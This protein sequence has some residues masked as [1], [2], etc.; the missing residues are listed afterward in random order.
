MH[1]PDL[2]RFGL[3]GRALDPVARNE[4]ARPF[5]GEFDGLPA[6]GIGGLEDQA[7]GGF[8]I[9]LEDQLLDEREA[10]AG[11]DRAAQ[12]HVELERA[13]GRDERMRK[14][15]ADSGDAAGIAPFRQ[16]LHGIE[17]RR[18]DHEFL[19]P[20][21]AFAVPQRLDE[22]FAADLGLGFGRAA[23]GARRSRAERHRVTPRNDAETMARQR[24]QPGKHG[25]E[26]RR[27]R[28]ADHGD[29]RQPARNLGQNGDERDA[30]DRQRGRDRRSRRGEPAADR[31]RQGFGEW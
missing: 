12:R 26:K 11:A 29:K 14:G 30:A 24:L 9:G 2:A 15:S 7:G 16:H 23:A 27:Q 10:L 25:G 19:Q 17:R 31:K 1:G 8:E 18:L 28:H 4:G 22:E 5:E 20:D 3:A 13:R 21:F 6:G